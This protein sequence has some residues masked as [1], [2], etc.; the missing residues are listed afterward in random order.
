MD[1][2]NMIKRALL[3]FTVLLCSLF[4][5]G[6]RTR[7]TGSVP[8][9]T[10]SSGISGEGIAQ[11]EGAEPSDA[12]MVN[13]ASIQAGTDISETEGTGGVTKENPDAQRKEYDENAPAE[14]VP[15]TDRL[16]HGEGEGS[17]AGVQ[18]AEDT[19]ESVSRLNEKAEESATQTV[20]AEEAEHMGVSED[21]EQADSALT[22]FTVLLEDRMGSLFECQRAYVYWE[23]Q[24]DHVTVYKT[25]MEHTLILNAGAYDVSARLLP[26]NL[27]VDDGWVMRKNP[28]VIVKIV[29]SSI[30]GSAVYSSGAAKAMYNSLCAREG[31]ANIDAVKNSQILLLSGEYLEA[32]Y[33]QTAAMVMIAMTANPDLFTDVDPQQ[34]LEMLCEE[35]TGTLPAGTWFFTGSEE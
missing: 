1:R 21:A 35:A 15:G 16:L 23:T 19:Q 34:M 30:L 22:Y 26:E 2:M 17:G 31:W 6:C 4:L 20:P 5:T 8:S 12:A 11:E 10:V 29:D 33:L 7:T 25:S 32:P 27:R 18:A 14:V 13:S 24:E 9:N 28:Q 3:L